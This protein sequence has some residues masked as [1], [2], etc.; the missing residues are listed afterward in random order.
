[1]RENRTYGLM[2]GRA[3]PTRDAPLYSTGGEWWSSLGYAIT[4]GMRQP[5]NFATDRCCHLV[6]RIANRAFYLS[7][8]ER[9]RFVERMRRVPRKVWR[10]C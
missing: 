7:E 9:T 6:S 1:M 5:R 3:Y 2:R 8:E 4:C 10:S